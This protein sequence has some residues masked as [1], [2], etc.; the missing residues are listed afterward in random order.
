MKKRGGA[1]DTRGKYHSVFPMKSFD[2]GSDKLQ[3]IS[4]QL[5]NQT[6]TPA[7]EEAARL[8]EEAT[9]QAKKIRDDARHDADQMLSKA[10]EQIRS[11]EKVLK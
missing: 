2:K 11:E 8:V 10:R 4:Q 3:A 7:K 9:L 6:I 5:R 1:C